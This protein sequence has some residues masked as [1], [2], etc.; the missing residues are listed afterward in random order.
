MLAWIWLRR[1]RPDKFGIGCNSRFL[2]IVHFFTLTF[3]SMPKESNK[4]K[5]SEKTTVTVFRH[6]RKAIFRSKKQ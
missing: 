2:I 6:L 1:A 5:A 4:E 3:F